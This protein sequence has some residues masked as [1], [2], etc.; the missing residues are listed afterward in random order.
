M[1]E[2]RDLKKLGSKKT[3]YRLDKPSV[4]ILETFENKYPHRDYRIEFIFPEFTSLCPKTG[5]PDFATIKIIYIPDKLCIESKSLKLYFFSYRQ[6]GSFME[7]ITNC[8]LE[9]LINVC[10]P[11]KMIVIGQFNARGGTFINVTARY[12]S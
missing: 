8:I 5:Q 12:P 10:N 9:D 4:D 1:Q 6:Y 2:G 3:V 7:T 11:R